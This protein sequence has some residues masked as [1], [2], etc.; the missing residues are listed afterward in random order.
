MHRGDAQYKHD[1]IGELQDGEDRWIGSEAEDHTTVLPGLLDQLLHEGRK[2]LLEDY[3]LDLEELQ[4]RLSVKAKGLGFAEVIR[5]RLNSGELQ[6]LEYVALK[7]AWRQCTDD[8]EIEQYD[9]Q[10][11]ALLE[12]LVVAH[13]VAPAA[14]DLWARLRHPFPLTDLGCGERFIE[15]QI[16]D[17]R[18]CPKTE[19]WYIWNGKYWARDS[20]N[21]LQARTLLKQTVRRMMIEAEKTGN[22][23]LEKYWKGAESPGKLNSILRAATLDQRIQIAPEEFD[24]H[25]WLLNFE[26]CT[27]ALNRPVS[28][29]YPH[30][31]QDYLTKIVPWPYDPK[32]RCPRWA[33]FLEQVTGGDREFQYFL[34]LIVG[35][36]LTGE[37]SEKCLFF[38]HGPTDTGKT[39]FIETIS[40]ML[41]EDY[42]RTTGFTS[43]VRGVKSG[44]RNDLARLQGVRFVAAS[45]AAREEK[46]DVVLLKRL[47]GDDTV[48]AR[49]L[50]REYSQFKPEFK[51]FLAAN[52][53]PELPAD[54]DAIW[55]RFIVIPFDVQVPHKQHDL[56]DR[57]R[58]EMPGIL[59]WA[60]H[61][62]WLYYAHYFSQRRPLELP[63]RVRRAIDGYRS[64]C[65]SGGLLTKAG[66]NKAKTLIKGFLDECCERVQGEE[67]A[68][69]D[70]LKAA[71]EWCEEH[72]EDSSL[73]T[74]NMLGRMLTQ[75]GYV[76]AAV[77]RDR[78]G[79]RLWKDIR[80]KR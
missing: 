53:E 71:Q 46:F 50:F 60:V 63:G 21:S 49:F 52:Y 73:V 26:N 43:F 17:V 38:L 58:D 42:A 65:D 72:F 34:Q 10:I 23:D 33:K 8:E 48:T 80:I 4:E 11:A 74:P 25:K 27:V 13:Y 20:R 15:E 45:E 29:S 16:E 24:R 77:T 31:R 56:K 19:S 40:A 1:Y 44:I 75:S 76:V 62:A 35:Y 57:L 64:R 41:G 2:L 39:T 47:T 30:S 61:G 7:R 79:K 9:E 59:A 28:K 18:F 54:D 12:R 5:H 51:I 69:E 70:L 66:G 55:R 3:R 14:K 36:G 32:A 67:A 37:V 68:P 78:V 22:T 6:D